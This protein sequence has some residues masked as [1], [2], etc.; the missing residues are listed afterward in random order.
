MSEAAFRLEGVSVRFGSAEALHDVDLRIEPGERV[1]ILGPSGAGKTT[2]LRVLGAAQRTSMGRVE[3]LGADVA[4]L[5]PRALRRLR[6]R[7][8]SVPQDLALLPGVRVLRNVLTGRI[9]AWSTAAAL[10]RI[11][12]PSR[13]VQAEVHELLERVGIG[14]KLF[15]R[16]E[17]LSL[18]QQQRVAVA[19]ALY[20]GPEVL[21][22]DEP[23]ASLD[24]SRAEAMLGLLDG[25]AWE[26][27][28]GLVVSLHDPGLAR[29]FFR[30]IVGLREGRV[31]FDLKADAIGDADLEWLYRIED[32]EV[33][34]A[35]TV[36]SLRVAA[37]ASGEAEGAAD[38]DRVDSGSA[39]E[40]RT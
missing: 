19:R 3:V 2:L 20:Q 6:A 14:E 35:N 18:G 11:A 5:R 10:L 13:R 40:E 9:G 37:R 25:I 17:H 8:G 16:T 23:V 31:V 15:E 28:T 36:P 4:A 39:D 29:R 32:D 22:A 21:L 1:A 24:P 26:R 38:E 34:S 30:R 12:F 33:E 7:I 27:R